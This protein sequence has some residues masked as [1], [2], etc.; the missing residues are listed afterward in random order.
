MTPTHFYQSE[1]RWSTELRR[2]CHTLS[3]CM[4]FKPPNSAVRQQRAAR[5]RQFIPICVRPRNLGTHP[6]RPSWTLFLSPNSPSIPTQTASIPIHITVHYSLSPSLSATTNIAETCQSPKV[7]ICRKTTKMRHFENEQS[8][9][10]GAV[11]AFVTSKTLGGNVEWLQHGDDFKNSRNS[12]MSA[13]RRS[14]FL[15]DLSSVALTTAGLPQT[16][17]F[18]TAVIP[19]DIPENP[20]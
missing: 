19:Q 14:S 17:S 7:L 20:R 6:N 13:I 16:T 10:N 15:F 5:G 18:T 9:T 11:S 1:I 4:R 12:L 3:P 2:G 8:S